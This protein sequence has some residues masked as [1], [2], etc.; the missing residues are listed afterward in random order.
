MPIKNRALHLE[1]AAYFFVSHICTPITAPLRLKRSK[2]K[3]IG[4]PMS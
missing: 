2:S 3:K 4:L 1:G